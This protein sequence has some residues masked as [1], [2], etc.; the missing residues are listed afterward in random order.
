MSLIATI[1]IVILAVQLIEKLSKGTAEIARIVNEEHERKR[2]ECIA[3]DVQ[4]RRSQM[5]DAEKIADTARAAKWVAENNPLVHVYLG[6]LG[7]PTSGEELRKLE[8][9]R[10]WQNMRKAIPY[11]E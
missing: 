1:L 2:K 11:K 9:H 8:E 3:R 5:T 6:P 10:A 4:W 7:S